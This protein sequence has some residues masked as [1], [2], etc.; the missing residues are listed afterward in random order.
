MCSRK[1]NIS[2]P[3][4]LSLSWTMWLHSVV[5]VEG[6]TKRIIYS[7]SFRSRRMAF[8]FCVEHKRKCSWKYNYNEWRQIL[9]GIYT[10]MHYIPIIYITL[11]EKQTNWVDKDTIFPL[12][13]GWTNFH[14]SLFSQF[15]LDPMS[16][17][18]LTGNLPPKGLT[19]QELELIGNS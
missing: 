11:C 3:E 7:P 13:L 14:S 8:F 18:F 1:T 9:K 12:C 4:L 17:Y 15:C 19:F 2:P 16:L 5:L 6:E 10:I